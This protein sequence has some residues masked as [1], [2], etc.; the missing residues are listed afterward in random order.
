MWRHCKSILSFSLKVSSNGRCQMLNYIQ[1]DMQLCVPH[2]TACALARK[3]PCN[4]RTHYLPCFLEQHIC[5]PPKPVGEKLVCTLYTRS[6]DPQ[7]FRNLVTRSSGNVNCHSF[8]SDSGSHGNAAIAPPPLHSQIP[9]KHAPPP[10]E[11]IAPCNGSGPTPSLRPSGG[12]RLSS[13][14]AATLYYGWVRTFSSLYVPFK[15]TVHI[16]CRG[17]LNLKNCGIYI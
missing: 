2:L 6:N 13:L 3:L 17:T 14:A 12:N 1:T 9:G 5:F 7:G 15:N 8:T 11:D 4:Y 16:I 10:P